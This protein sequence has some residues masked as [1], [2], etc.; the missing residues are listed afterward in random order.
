MGRQC[1]GRTSTAPKDPK[2]PKGLSGPRGITPGWVADVCLL[3]AD[4]KG[5]WTKV[6]EKGFKAKQFEGE[7][8]HTAYNKDGCLVK[9][10]AHFIADQFAKS[11]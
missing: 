8:P 4:N 9:T 11:K 2:A 3:D 1:A 5:D 6:P 10:A 7:I